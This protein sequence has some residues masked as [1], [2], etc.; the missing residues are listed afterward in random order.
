MWRLV[1]G[2]I[3]IFIFVFIYTILFAYVLIRAPDVYNAVWFIYYLS[4]PSSILYVFIDAY[5][6]LP[7]HGIVYFDISV[8]YLLGV[9]Q[10]G[11]L[12]WICQKIFQGGYFFIKRYF[13]CK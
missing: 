3:F 10:Y 6:S 1:I 13:L 9:I 8:M 5:F 4:I 7:T 11:I 12:G 2:K